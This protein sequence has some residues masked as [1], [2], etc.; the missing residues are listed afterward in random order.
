MVYFAHQE[1]FLYG[2]CRFEDWF[3]WRF[4]TIILKQSL[5]SVFWLVWHSI[6]PSSLSKSALFWTFIRDYIKL[7][8]LLN[9]YLFLWQASKRNCVGSE[10]LLPRI[11]IF[12]NMETIFFNL[13]SALLFFCG[14]FT[15]VLFLFPSFGDSVFLFFS[16]L[17]RL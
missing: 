9:I 10:C 5:L 12:L 6:S 16:F 15:L 3:F 7:W 1:L 17:W 8:L 2:C 13:F 4:F 11:V 14:D